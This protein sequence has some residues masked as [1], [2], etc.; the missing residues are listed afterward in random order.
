MDDQASLTPSLSHPMGEGAPSRIGDCEAKRAD[1]P[2]L[3]H[4]MGEGAPSRI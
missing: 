2:S 1:T 3:P 4:P